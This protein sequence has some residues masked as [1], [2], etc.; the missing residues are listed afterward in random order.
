MIYLE[1]HKL[2]NQVTELDILVDQKPSKAGIDSIH[3]LIDRD[4]E[5][6]VK[7]LSQKEARN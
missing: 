1:K 4:I 5:N 7:Q 6:N 2:T 3:K